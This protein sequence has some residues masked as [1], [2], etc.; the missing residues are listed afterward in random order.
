LS[1]IEIPNVQIITIKRHS[2]RWAH[3]R[4]VFSG[5]VAR[6]VLKVID[7]VNPDIIH[8]HSITWQIGYKWIHGA[9]KRK[10]PCFFTHH[11][12]APVAYWKVTGKERFLVLRDLFLARWT[13]NPLRNLLIRRALNKT[14]SLCVSNALKQYLERFGYKNLETLHNGID[15]NFWESSDDKHSIRQKLG[16]PANAPVFLLAGRLGHDKGL[17]FL[18]N[19]WPSLKGDPHLIL[20]G[21]MP[22]KIPEKLKSQMHVFLN[23][24]PEK[25][26]DHYSACDVSLIPS[27]CFDSFPTVALESM[28]CRRPVISAER[29]GG[30]ESIKDGETGWIVS[31]EDSSAWKERL[32]WCI[33]HR[34]ELSQFGEAGR[35]RMKKEFSL[36]KYIDGLENLYKHIAKS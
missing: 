11:S 21:Q 13:F 32:Q 1:L 35:R 4:S 14:H 17:V 25:M 19:L 34:S 10:I 30:N 29:G 31:I 18:W 36:E 2:K 20:A 33:D 22:L 16:I 6:E 23:Q 15:V 3:Y 26:R 8:G 24:S 9:T 27:I 5:R 28:A 7:E 12:V